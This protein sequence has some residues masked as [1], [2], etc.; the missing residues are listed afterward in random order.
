MPLSIGDTGETH[1]GE[2]LSGK[3]E[4]REYRLRLSLHHRC[5][6]E[7]GATV[8]RLHAPR[9]MGFCRLG[10]KLDTTL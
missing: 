8:V 2:M 9:I 10:V 3:D 4:N 5:S 7:Q 6:A 1:V